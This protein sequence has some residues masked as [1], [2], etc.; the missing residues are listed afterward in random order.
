[1]RRSVLFTFDRETLR[2][3]RF[4]A[5]CRL[6]MPLRTAPPRGNASRR[7]R[8]SII[9]W[10]TVQPKSFSSLWVVACTSSQRLGERAGGEDSPGDLPDS[11]WS[12]WKAIEAGVGAP[13]S[14][15]AP[16]TWITV[17]QLALTTGT[18]EAVV[19][20]GFRDPDPPLYP[21]EEHRTVTTCSHH[22][23]HAPSIYPTTTQRRFLPRACP[24]LLFARLPATYCAYFFA[25][26]GLSACSGWRASS[27]ASEAGGTRGGTGLIRRS[28]APYRP[29]PIVRRR[30][31][32]PVLRKAR[33][34]GRSFSAW[35]SSKCGAPEVL[36]TPC[37]AWSSARQT[38][39]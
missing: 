17:S 23:A 8:A 20:R 32:H 35:R 12:R 7:S 24:C 19:A 26:D 11:R 1:M 10:Q 18:V 39:I 16:S 28:S 14:S 5:H 33:Q 27:P 15:R 37:H 22:S 34:S 29:N 21:D 31:I 25:P 38:G 30:C 2:R 13:E 9:F 4:R 36:K 3:R 6:G